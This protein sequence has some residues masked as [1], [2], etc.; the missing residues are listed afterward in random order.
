[1][2]GEADPDMIAVQADL[3]RVSLRELPDM[4]ESTDTHRR[5]G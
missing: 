3:I 1:M 4:M 2:Q 5:W